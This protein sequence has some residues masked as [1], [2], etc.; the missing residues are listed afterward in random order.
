MPERIST[1]NKIR[2]SGIWKD[3]LIVD[4]V[5]TYMSAESTLKDKV[6]KTSSIVIATS[7]LFACADQAVNTPGVDSTLPP[8]T[9]TTEIA[10]ASEIDS[11][12]SASVEWSARPE[13]VDTVKSVVENGF[14]Q[15]DPGFSLPADSVSS[16]AIK[17]DRTVIGLSPLSVE[18][19]TTNEPE[20][21]SAGQLVDN[22]VT[23][24]YMF[25]GQPDEPA[26]PLYR[27]LFDKDGQQWMRQYAY[28][29]LGEVQ[30]V[31]EYPADTNERLEKGET[32]TMLFY[33]SADQKAQMGKMDDKP[34]AVKVTPP[35]NNQVASAPT[36][37]G[38]KEVSFVITATPI[39]ATET[40]I[41]TATVEATRTPEVS[42]NCP[43]NPGAFNASEISLVNDIKSGK[44]AEWVLKL[45]QAQS[46]I[47]QNPSKLDYTNS[48]SDL[49][50][51]GQLSA[52]L[53]DDTGWS[54]RHS[55]Y[56]GS[57]NI[58]PA[59]LGFPGKDTGRLLISVIQDKNDRRA[60]QFT[61]V[62]AHHADSMKEGFVFSDKIGNSIIPLDSASNWDDKNFIAP[63]AS[64]GSSA[65]LRVMQD[66]SVFYGTQGT[67]LEEVK[68]LF[69]EIA[70]TS[71][72]TDDIV[73]KLSTTIFFGENGI[74]YRN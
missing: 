15:Y 30:V 10:P 1:L 6:Y 26:E 13:T 16:Y 53:I 50:G 67:S 31:Q 37:F 69:S 14:R 3:G 45:P 62:A 56:I 60:V 5:N 51:R 71:T 40:P 7:V 41:A 4:T 46:K 73:Q 48:V 49:D 32:V 63:N 54:A 59:E 20:L 61:F 52:Q 8:G 34:V 18:F 66:E 24:D 39:P 65:D 2:Q 22:A 28:S 74:N 70:E 11:A 64:P 9:G 57:C 58:N 35:S 33:P 42:Y 21:N 43:E 29:E 36:P 68:S 17:I 55:L 47:S 27:Q 25:T 23:R 44:L 38:N 72:F 12:Y 19:V